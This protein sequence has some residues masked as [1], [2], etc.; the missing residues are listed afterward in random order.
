MAYLYLDPFSGL[1]GN[2]MLGVLFAMGLDFDQF[3]TELEK[4]NVTG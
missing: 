3:Q 1:S 4:K 2:M